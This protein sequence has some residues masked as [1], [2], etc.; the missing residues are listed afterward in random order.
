MKP[1]AK[2]NNGSG[3][4]KGVTVHNTCDITVPTGTNP[5]EQYARATWPNCNMGGVVVHFYV[6]RNIIWQLLDET[7]RGWHATDG[8]SRRGSQRTGETIGG[9]LDTIAIEAI[10]KH[11]ETT[12]TT[13]LLT[14]YLMQEHSLSPEID[15][16]NH[17][18]F[19]RPKLCPVW[20]LPHW[21]AFIATV[22]TFC[23]AG[24]KPVAGLPESG[25]IAVGDVVAFLGGGVYASSAAFAPA[26]NRDSSNCKVTH[27]V[28]QAPRPYHLVSVDGG[29]VFGWV[30]ASSI[31]E[32]MESAGIQVGSLIMVTGD[33]YATGQNIPAWVKNQSHVVA[34]ISDGRALLGAGG[35]IN[36][37]VSI[38]D[39]RLA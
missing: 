24:N 22:K 38:K 23:N 28:Q 26:G 35:G 6:W 3:K 17:N 10:G 19:H 18:F 33:R 14:A 13:A 37:W 36:S 39:I 27:V 25:E 20:I 15:V 4:P 34:Q 8:T 11:P 31:S 5:A 32:G 30:D 2:L 12:E 29:G 16:Y 9:N 21:C 1:N 7:E